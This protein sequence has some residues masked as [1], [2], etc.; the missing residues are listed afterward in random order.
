M[1]AAYAF[2]MTKVKAAF[3]S[4]DYKAVITEGERIISE[5][6]DV[7][8]LG[9]LYYLLGLSYLKDGNA[10]RATDIFEI[11]INEFSASVLRADAMLALGDAYYVLQNYTKAAQWYEALRVDKAGGRLLPLAY[12]RLRQCALVVGDTQKAKEYSEILSRKFPG[13]SE[14]DPNVVSSDALEG[15]CVQ[16]GS[17]TKKKNADSLVQ[18]LS[19]KGFN[20]YIEEVVSSGATLYS[21]RVGK[22]ILRRDAL[23]SE[24][25]LSQEGY[26]VQVYP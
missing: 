23:D 9:E 14:A 19:A 8:Q 15:Y 21:V 10:L 4:G 26:S 3:L 17:F 13:Y 20:A 6:E 5:T 12:L 24:L 2:D 1:P 11:I 25:K 18:K 16:A 22:F 7:P